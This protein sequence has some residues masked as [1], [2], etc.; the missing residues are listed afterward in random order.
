MLAIEVLFDEKLHNT[1]AVEGLLRAE[2]RD[3]QRESLQLREAIVN[4][5]EVLVMGVLSG[6]DL[7]QLQDV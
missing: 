3:K 2:C 1:V 5:V 6:R 7:E 4:V